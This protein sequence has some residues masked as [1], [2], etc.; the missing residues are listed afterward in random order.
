M[1]NMRSR[2]H[3]SKSPASGSIG[4]RAARVAAP[5]VAARTPRGS[6]KGG[7]YNT[8][9]AT[10]AKNRFGAILKSIR[11]AE[12][13]F[14][15]RHGTA[16]AVVLDIESYHALVRR[17]REPHEVRLEALREEFEALYSR[18]QT[19]RS[20]KA[21]DLLSSASADELNQVAAIR[22]RTRG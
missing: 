21:V 13:V 20:R 14:I 2:R 3:A 16:Q 15:E 5:A 10:Q 6:L 8:V 12:P 7:G 4:R 9:K 1:T 11:N 22:A 19:A 18:M 17:A